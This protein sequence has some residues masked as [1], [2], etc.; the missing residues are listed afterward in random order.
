MTVALRMLTSLL[1]R[2][3]WHGLGD[4]TFEGS[5]GVA[6]WHWWDPES[7]IT[8]VRVLLY[9]GLCIVGLV[10]LQEF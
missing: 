8:R 5:F 9:S 7:D 3:L 1:D 4:T 2:A 6:L 10:T